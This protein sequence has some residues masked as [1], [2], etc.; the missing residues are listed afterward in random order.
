MTQVLGAAEAAEAASIVATR[1][2]NDAVARR[3]DSR[4]IVLSC[5]PALVDIGRRGVN[6]AARG[7]PV[8]DAHG[9]WR[10]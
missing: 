6:F 3:I 9:W 2:M 7:R 4:M 10:R 8:G 1:Q 5:S